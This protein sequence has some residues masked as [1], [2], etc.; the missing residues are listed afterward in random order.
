MP[1]LSKPSDL[2]ADDGGRVAPAVVY[3]AKSTDDPRGSIA[4]Q[5]AHCEALCKR[6]GLIVAATYADEAK[7]AYHGSRGQG[8]VQT[9]EHAEKLAAEHGGLRD[10]GAAH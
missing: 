2:Q 1:T 6:H 5:I 7:S 4:T 9:R 8:L 10:R 3:A